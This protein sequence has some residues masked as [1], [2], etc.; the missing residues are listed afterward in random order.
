MLQKKII[1]I[2]ILS[3]IALILAA[4]PIIEF[5]QLNHNFGDIKEE[6]GSVTHEFTFTNTGDEPLIL[7]KVKAS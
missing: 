6:D 4:E 3:L 7:V 1:L 5:N 2:I